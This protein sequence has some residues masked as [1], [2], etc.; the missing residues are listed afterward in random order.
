[1]GFA[2]ALGKPVYSFEQPVDGMLAGRTNLTG[3]VFQ[4]LDQL[5]L[6]SF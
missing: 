6:T 1:M 3:S 2:S 5:Q 4:I